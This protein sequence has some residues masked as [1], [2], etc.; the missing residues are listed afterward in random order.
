MAEFLAGYVTESGTF[1]PIIQSAADSSSCYKGDSQLS[2]PWAFLNSE[3]WDLM[4]D[5]TEWYEIQSSVTSYL[6]HFCEDFEMI[7]KQDV[8]FPW[9]VP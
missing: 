5:S 1:P 3:P 9:S 6:K 7:F 4:W 8:S 2:A